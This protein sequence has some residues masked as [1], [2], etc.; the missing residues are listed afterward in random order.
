MG[1]YTDSFNNKI[2][3]SDTRGYERPMFQTFLTAPEWRNVDMSGELADFLALGNPFYRFPYF[4]QTAVFWRVFADSYR[5]AGQYNRHVDLIFSEH[6][7]MNL[8][9]GISTTIE[10]TTK[11]ILSKLIS[12]F[13]AI[14]NNTELQSA[15]ADIF[16]DYAQFIHSVP[17]YDYPY[18]SKV[19]PL[20]KA[21]LRSPN[22][23]LADVVTLFSTST[24]FAIRDAISR[25]ISWW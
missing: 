7:I 9:I 21:F 13:L 25:P 18:L 16:R 10:F 19:G 6:M 1:K 20:W 17:F 4:K 5:A 2:R 3:A 8:F 22:K 11:G 15:V 23:T 12:P 14:R 24:E